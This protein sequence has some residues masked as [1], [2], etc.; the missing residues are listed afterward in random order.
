[1]LL[2]SHLPPVRT[3]GAAGTTTIAIPNAWRISHTEKT[4]IFDGQAIVPIRETGMIEKNT[5]TRLFAGIGVS[6]KA[7]RGLDSRAVLFEVAAPK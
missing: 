6:L 2:A 3:A 1:V 4:W 5:G 7:S